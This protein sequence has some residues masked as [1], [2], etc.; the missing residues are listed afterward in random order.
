[1]IFHT[2]NKED[3]VVGYLYNG[4]L[5]IDK[6]NLD[7]KNSPEEENKIGARVASLDACRIA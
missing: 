6:L 3:S 5:D 4:Q 1:M 2:L 7:S